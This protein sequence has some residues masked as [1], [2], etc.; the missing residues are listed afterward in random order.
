MSTTLY[1]SKVNLNSH[2]YNAYNKKSELNKILTLLYTKINDNIIYE[3]EITGFDTDGNEFNSLV[4]Y[5]FYSI[6]K[7]DKDLNYT[8]TGRIIKKMNIFINN[9]NEDTGEVVKTPVEHSEVIDFYFDVFKEIVCFH[10]TNRF[11]YVEFNDIFKELI[12]LSMSDDPEKYYFD[13]SLWRQ[14][15]N[16]SDIRKQLIKLGKIETLKIDII[17]PNPD[18]D[19]LDNIQNNG[20]E[21]LEK[22]KNGNVTHRSILFTSK[23]PEGL[24]LDADIIDNELQSIENIHSSLTSEEATRNGYVSLD[25]ISKHGRTY[26]TEDSKPIKD[27][28]DSKPSNLREFALACKNKVNAILSSLL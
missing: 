6:E 11:G 19:L 25:A 24:N 13:V 8:I 4:T 17:P 18:D 26:T 20:E 28:L 3:K 22:Y 10:T 7:F 27:K 1:F 21:F 9:L 14:G 15:L 16:L 2:I 12:N 5:K 23:A